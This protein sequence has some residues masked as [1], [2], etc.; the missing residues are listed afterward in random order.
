[1]IYL[2][3]CATTK[4]REEVL[5]KMYESLKHD[6]ANPSSL[7]DLGI[8]SE[9]KIK[10]AREIISKFMDVRPSELYF[11][12]GGTES[13]NIAIQSVVNK[14]S[15]RGKHLITTEIEHPSVLNVMKYLETKGYSVTYLKVD[16]NGL[17]DLSQLEDSITDETILISIIHVNNEIGSIQDIKKIRQIIDNK[18][19]NTI[20]HL[21][22]IQSFGK[23][24]FNLNDLGVDLF[25]FSGHKIYG[26]KGIG[27]LFIKDS[28]NLDPIT[29]GGGQESGMRSGT[30]NLTGI[31]GI[32]EAI[33]LIDKNQKAD[34]E[35][36]SS[37]KKHMVEKIKENI[38]DIK[39]N[40]PLDETGSPYILNVSFKNTRGEVLL[41][42]LEDKK[43]YI[44]T[45]SA[46]S[47]KGTEKSHVLKAI[48]LEDEYIEGAIRMCFSY[49][50]GREDLDYVVE[51]LKSS[52]EEIRKIIMR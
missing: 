16:G 49:D 6:F 21:D 19:K 25:S 48:D 4:I 1:M 11:T 27:G 10:E 46:C 18:N 31:I 2:D 24:Y 39:I 41:H 45:T 28:L 52:V 17:I 30:E 23:I 42:Y 44:S 38:E 26:P 29:F 33:R 22:G 51:V 14:Y 12:S 50:I 40:S 15:N 8:N 37:L 34:I 32:G 36:V 3:N 47:S 35:Y 9:K 20:L 43:I 13:N 7:H 5:E